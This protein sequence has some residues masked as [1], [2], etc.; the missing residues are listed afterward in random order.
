[1]LP[2][3]KGPRVLDIGTGAGLPGIPLALARPDLQFTLLDSNAKKLSFV[4]QAVHDLD[5]RNVVVAHAR[6][7][8]FQPQEKF[9]TL[10][11]RAVASLAEIVTVSRHLFAPGG[12][13]LA[14][15]GVFPRGEITALGDDYRIDIKALSVPGLGAERH[16]VIVEPH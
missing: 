13:L 12:R 15:K 5:I 9:D 7:E 11:A 8:N 2:W 1:V 10:I 14:M 16:L 4:R 3:L 6:A